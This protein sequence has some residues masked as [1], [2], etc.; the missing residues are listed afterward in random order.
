MACHCIS[1]ITA[2]HLCGVT[3]GLHKYNWNQNQSCWS[4]LFCWFSYQ[5]GCLQ[6]ST[7]P[8][9]LGLCG[10]TSCGWYLPQH[11]SLSQVCACLAD[12]HTW[13]RSW[14]RFIY[15]ELK[16]IQFLLIVIDQ[17]PFSVLL[18]DPIP[19]VTEALLP[20]HTKVVPS[21][22]Q[23]N[24][25]QLRNSNVKL[26]S[27]KMGCAKWRL[28]SF[29]HSSLSVLHSAIKHLLSSSSALH[30]CHFWRLVEDEWITSPRAGVGAFLGVKDCSEVWQKQ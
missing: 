15:G 3:P 23:E 28:L 9:L 22:S 8:E 11:R 14:H 29:C 21:P 25:I 4:S 16:L 30:I 10:F 20:Y 12:A 2:P 13:R 18:N 1:T 7:G 26:Q 24:K 5:D 19:V 6:S 27:R 17:R